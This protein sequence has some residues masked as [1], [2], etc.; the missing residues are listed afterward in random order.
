[1]KKRFLTLCLAACFLAGCEKNP[2]QPLVVHKDMD[3]MIQEAET[4]DEGKQDL[5]AMLEAKP[6]HYRKDFANDAVGVKVHVDADVVLPDA[7]QFSVMR[8]RKMPLTQEFT[9]KVRNILIGDTPMFEARSLRQRI[10][11]DYEEMIAYYRQQIAE[12]TDPQNLKALNSDLANLEESYN[13][14]PDTIRP[15]DYPSDGKLQSVRSLYES[16]TANEYY[17]WAMEFNP[18]GERLYEMNLGEDDNHLLFTAENNP[19]RGSSISYNRSPIT[20]MRYDYLEKTIL[21]PDMDVKKHRNLP[22][23]LLTHRY[24]VSAEWKPIPGDGV[25]IS[26]EEAKAEAEN[27]LGA[28]GL[29]D[30]AFYEG[31]LYPEMMQPESDCIYYRTDY[32]LRYY[33]CYNGIFCTQSSGEKYESEYE[34]QF[35]VAQRKWEGEYIEIRVDDTGIVGF[36]YVSPLEINE[37]IVENASM[38]PFSEIKETFERMLPVTIAADGEEITVAAEITDIILD[39]SR[40]SEQDRF[41]TGLLVPVW[42]FIGTRNQINNEGYTI[43]TENTTL[44]SINAIDGTIIDRGLGC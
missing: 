33:R 41:D 26:E 5:S 15:E 6:E 24:D 27:L 35:G 40:I 9:D 20:W 14:A 38:K 11:A 18:N 4:P 1:M 21:E 37:T 29:T 7:E 28:L 30:F 22:E 13:N 3:H 12:E 16:E 32:I 44:M 8:V 17:Q 19:D 34:Y 10:K 2:E 31:G 23:N 25:T 42:S 43:L 39:Y 36:H